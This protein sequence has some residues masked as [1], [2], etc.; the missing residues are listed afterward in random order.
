MLDVTPEKIDR[1]SF[2][3]CKHMI[4]VNLLSVSVAK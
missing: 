4:I 3:P 1:F 2:D